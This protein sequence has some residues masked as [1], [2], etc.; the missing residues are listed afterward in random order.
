MRGQSENKEPAEEL[1]GMGR[2][3]GDQY[4]SYGTWQDDRLRLKEPVEKI[5]HGIR[6]L[7]VFKGEDLTNLQNAA[8]EEF[9]KRMQ[10]WPEP[11]IPMFLNNR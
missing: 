3:L 5:L 10:N 2:W 9:I 4:S 11:K 7:R 6:A 1:W 8:I